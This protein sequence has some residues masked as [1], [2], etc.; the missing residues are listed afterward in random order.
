MQ[1]TKRERHWI[2]VF[3]STQRGKYLV[4]LLFPN[5]A[6]SRDAPSEEEHEHATTSLRERGVKAALCREVEMHVTVPP[7]V[8]RDAGISVFELDFGE[9]R[10]GP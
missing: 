8:L 4:P 6:H 7:V 1:L 10:H 9:S 2:L 5:L 3:S